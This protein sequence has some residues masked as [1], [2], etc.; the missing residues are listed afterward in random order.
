VKANAFSE[1]K[2]GLEKK[3]PTP[4]IGDVEVAHKV[5]STFQMCFMIIFELTLKRKCVKECKQFKYEHEIRL[6]R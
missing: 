5:V 6:K 1:P 3:R 2:G 4:W